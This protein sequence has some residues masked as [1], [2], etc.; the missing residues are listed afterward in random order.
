[1]Q[2]RVRQIKKS[3]SESVDVF[4]K[5]GVVLSAATIIYVNNTF[6]Y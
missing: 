1:M 6:K 3:A 4:N 5:G 2:V